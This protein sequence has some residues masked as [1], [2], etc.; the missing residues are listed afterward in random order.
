MDLGGLIEEEDRINICQGAA[1]FGIFAK[2]QQNLLPLRRRSQ[3]APRLWVWITTGCGPLEYASASALEEIG[4]GR[5]ADRRVSFAT[6]IVGSRAEELLRRLADDGAEIVDHMCLV[7]EAA[8]VA[9]KTPAG[10]DPEA[11]FA[12]SKSP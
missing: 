12:A 9:G 10:Q 3:N 6:G 8:G 11:R 4:A 7:G 1:E 5:L 2:V